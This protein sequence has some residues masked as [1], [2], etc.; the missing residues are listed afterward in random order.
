MGHDGDKLGLRRSGRSISVRIEIRKWSPDTN[1]NK[2][3][4]F[5]VSWRFDY[6]ITLYTLML[7]GKMTSGIF[8]GRMTPLHLHQSTLDLW[9]LSVS[10]STEASIYL[11]MPSLG[12]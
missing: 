5:D 3:A 10:E 4:Q 6:F 7:Y 8:G 12:L 1:K 9:K 11:C 2:N